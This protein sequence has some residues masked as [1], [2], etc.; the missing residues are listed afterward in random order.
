MPAFPEKLSYPQTEHNAFALAGII[1]YDESSQGAMT[2]ATCP[3]CGAVNQGGKAACWK[4]LAPIPPSPPASSTPP[5]P[6]PNQELAAPVRRKFNIPDLTVAFPKRRV[7]P[8]Q[9]TPE[10]LPAPDSS[11]VEPTATPEARLEAEPEAQRVPEAPVEEESDATGEVKPPASEDTA[12]ASP[13]GDDIPVDPGADL[14][15]LPHGDRPFALADE[16]DEDPPAPN[17]EFVYIARAAV[18]RRD[19]VWIPVLVLLVLLLSG[20]FYLYHRNFRAQPRPQTAAQAAQEYLFALMNDRT[21]QQQLATPDSR[22]LLLPTWFT[23]AET[24]LL[25]VTDAANGT[26]TARSRLTLAPIRSAVLQ[27][28][29]EDAA[30]RDYTVEFTLKRGRACWLVDQRT[31]FR[32]LRVQMKTRNPGVTLPPWDGV[33]Q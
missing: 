1:C 24:R 5:T 15:P 28:A 31:L 12:S 16:E 7:Q 33:S 3:R 23:I 19:T 21:T 17:R 2:M 10:E 13:A 6:L 30:S 22:G 26:A 8:A 32:S 25:G 20:I 27:Q 14:S 18:P 9:L 4:C 11:E 29:L